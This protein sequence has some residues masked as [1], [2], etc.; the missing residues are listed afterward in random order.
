[1]ENTKQIHA[2]A[3]FAEHTHRAG[4]AVTLV[5]IEPK[6]LDDVLRLWDAA[7]GTNEDEDSMDVARSEL[8]LRFNLDV[9]D[10]VLFTGTLAELDETANRYIKD[11]RSIYTNRIGWA[12]ADYVEFMK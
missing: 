2:V 9:N 10:N 1:M 11:E 6:Y 7:D 4:R 8:E 12:L 3:L 5:P